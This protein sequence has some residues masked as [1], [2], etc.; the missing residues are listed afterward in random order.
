MKELD[1]EWKPY[2]RLGHIDEDRLSD[3]LAARARLSLPGETMPKRWIYKTP[4]DFCER[5]GDEP[6]WA[7][8]KSYHCY[9]VRGQYM[10]RIWTNADTPY[11]WVDLA[12]VLITPLSPYLDYENIPEGS[13]YKCRPLCYRARLTSEGDVDILVKL[14]RSLYGLH[15]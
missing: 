6:R 15:Q 14:I 3:K 8:T 7:L 9:L 1:K 12:S 10:F 4:E 2:D 5:F 13:R 11:A